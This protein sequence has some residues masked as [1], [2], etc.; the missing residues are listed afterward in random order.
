MRLE[1]ERCFCCLNRSF[2]DV[3]GLRM[4]GLG[5]F[6]KKSFIEVRCKISEIR[7]GMTGIVGIA[8]VKEYRN[9]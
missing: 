2:P 7:M 4:T 6:W 8:S 3:S 5:L 9:I 1:G